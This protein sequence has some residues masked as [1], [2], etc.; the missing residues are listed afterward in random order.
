[1]AGFM[2]DASTLGRLVFSTKKRNNMDKVVNKAWLESVEKHQNEL[3]D[4][5]KRLIEYK[6]RNPK[7]LWPILDDLIFYVTGERPYD[8][9]ES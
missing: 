9:D 8:E 2:A 4:A 1:M 5:R 6:T 7:R 3:R